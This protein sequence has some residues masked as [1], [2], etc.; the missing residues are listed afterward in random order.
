MHVLLAHAR[1]LVH[2]LAAMER[3]ERTAIVIGASS[4]GGLGEAVAR[5]LAADG[6]RLILAGRRLEPLERLALETG[7]RAVACDIT[8]EASIMALVAQAGACD[9]LVNAAGTTLGQSILKLQREQIEAQLAIHVTGNLLLLKHAGPAMTAG[10]SIVLFSSVT[11][12]RAGYAL[13]AYAAAKAGLEQVV[14]VAALEF[15]SLGIR[16]NAVAPGFSFTPMTEGFLAKPQLHALY[17]RESALDALVTPEQVAATV[18]HLVAPDCF[19]TGE[20]VQVSGG[21][22]LFRLPTTHELKAS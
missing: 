15:G 21:A 11:A 13:A 12:Q 6:V 1:Q 10:G 3:I 19:I 9:V 2:K 16:V 7:G 17:R 8:D 18:A 5:R 20:I 14:R 4:P 22:Q